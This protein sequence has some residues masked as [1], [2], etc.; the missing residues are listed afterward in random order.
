MSELLDRRFKLINPHKYIFKN[1]ELPIDVSLLNGLKVYYG[2]TAFLDR[3][4]IN[5][6]REAMGGNTIR[7]YNQL[8]LLIPAI[9]NNQPHISLVGRIVLTIENGICKAEY[10]AI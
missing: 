5:I 2:L 1:N 8:S 6:L 9:L 10:E 3:E 4:S 7:V